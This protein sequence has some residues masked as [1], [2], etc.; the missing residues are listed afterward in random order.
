MS[1]Q[2]RS[3]DL[4]RSV[5]SVVSGFEDDQRDQ[6]IDNLVQANEKLVGEVDSMRQK[7]KEVDSK[8][9]KERQTMEGD[10]KHKEQGLKEECQKLEKRI[11]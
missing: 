2:N 11:H 5:Q 7:L 10:F 9:K 6:E 4:E 3:L 8:V 1:H